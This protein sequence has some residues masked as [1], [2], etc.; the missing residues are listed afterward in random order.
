MTCL[1][2][3]VNQMVYCKLKETRTDSA[4]YNIGRDVNDISGEVI[5]YKGLRE[6]ELLKQAKEEPIRTVHL[7]KIYGKYREDFA[8]GDFKEKLA[9][10]IG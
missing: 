8:N 1:G 4:I 2:K 9:F 5:F 6:P 3:K 10:E 7:A